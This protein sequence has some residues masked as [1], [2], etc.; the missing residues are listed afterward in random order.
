MVGGDYYSTNF[1]TEGAIARIK[2][3]NKTKPFWLH[4]T[5]QAV[6]T[7]AARLP[8]LWEQWA[9]DIGLKQ[10]LEYRSALHVL[11]VGLAN[12]T[13]TLK[14]EGMWDNTLFL[15]TAGGLRRFVNRP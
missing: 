6:H 9:G 8:P 3:R 10:S 1:F 7:G 2:G 11:D 15:L 12:L 5:Y 13:A 14:E 4:L